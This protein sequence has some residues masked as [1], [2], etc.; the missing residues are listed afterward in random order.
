MAGLGFEPSAP[1]ALAMV[2][3]P[4]LVLVNYFNG[5]GNA[6]PVATESN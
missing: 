3:L 6:A 4:P 1:A 5:R 2:L